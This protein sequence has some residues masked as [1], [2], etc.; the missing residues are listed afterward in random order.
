MPAAVH[1]RLG[2]RLAESVGRQ[3]VMGRELAHLLRA[4]A[5]ERLPV[6]P[7][8]GPALAET[9][10]ADPALRPFSDL[11]LLIRREHVLAADGLLQALGYR[12]LADGHSWEFDL[13]YDRAALYEGPDGVQVD[14]HW[15]LLSDPR[16]VWEESAGLEVW[17]RMIKSQIDGQTVLGLCPED[18]LLYLATHLAVHHGLAGLLWYWDLALLLDRWGS[19][20]D[21]PTVLERA[22]RWR[23]RRALGFALVGCEIFFERKV[24]EPVK[25]RLRAQGP[26]AA[27]LRRLLRHREADRLA[28]LEHVIALLLV[29]RG[30]DVIGALGRVACPSPA[31]VRARYGPGSTLLTAY[32]AHYRRMACVGRGVKEGL[33][34]RPG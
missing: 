10:Y 30:R 32:A 21:W 33:A 1:D 16:Y 22:A 5:R 31:W 15:S 2:R 19:R 34:S 27:L 29:D 24:P 9:L 17:E 14:L 4:F 26:R 6:I 3:L 25:A 8:K 13:A 7:L 28:R 23:V 20:L 12:R 11:D 18:L